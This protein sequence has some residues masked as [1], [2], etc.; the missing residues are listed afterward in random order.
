MCVWGGGGAKVTN[1]YDLTRKQH[2][3]V[4]QCMRKA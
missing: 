4:V 1:N 2:E 3:G